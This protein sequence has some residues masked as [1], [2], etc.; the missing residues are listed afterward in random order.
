MSHGFR[1]SGHK[2]RVVI[3]DRDGVIN[4]DSDAYI[5]SPAEWH[6]IPGSLEAIKALKEAG[7]RVFVATNQSGLARG[8]FAPSALAAMHEKLQQYLA[9]LGT[10]VDGIYYC[11]H[12]PDDGCDCRKPLP[13]LLHR[14]AREHRVALN[15]VPVVGD[16]LRDL[17]AAAAVGAK[18][19]LVKTGKGEKTLSGPLP[20]GTEVYTDLAAAAQGLIAHWADDDRAEG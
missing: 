10:A 18:P 17:E 12:G 4:I 13:G 16:S 19:I 15:D 9:R 3:L 2:G 7:A 5:K 20:E 8:L 11:P 14:I 1:D 6:P